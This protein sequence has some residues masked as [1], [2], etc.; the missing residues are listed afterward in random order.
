MVDDESGRYASEFGD[1]LDSG[2]R[3]GPQAID[4]VAYA[5]ALTAT[6]VVG[7]GGVSVVLGAGLVGLKYGL[8]VVGILLFGA[9]SL[10]LRPSAP[11]SD[12]RNLLPVDSA[13]ESGFQAAVQ[14]ALPERYR[15]APDERLSDALKLFLASLA[16]LGCSFVMERA[17]GVVVAGA[18]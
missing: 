13:E 1:E 14:R 6:L 16:V 5:L 9:A 4:A 10:K 7:L 12:T 17:F 3:R 11:Y 18:G 2:P 15:L 8:F